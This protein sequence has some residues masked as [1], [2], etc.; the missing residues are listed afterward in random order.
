MH[1]LLTQIVAS[2]WLISPALAQ[3][4][5]PMLESMAQGQQPTGVGADAALAR[6]KQARPRDY[7]VL[8][9]AGGAV[10]AVAPIAGG[11][12]TAKSESNSLNV[13][14]IGISGPLLKDDQECGPLGMSTLAR[15]VQAL[16]ND[17]HVDAVVFKIDSPGGQVY[18]TQTLADAIMQC[19]KPTV[20]LCDDGLMCS[21]AYW[22]GASC[23]RVLATHETCTIGS[24]GVMASWA[25]KSGKLEKE[26]VVFHEVYA[27][28]ST[29]KNADFAAAKAG[30]YGP[31]QERLSAICDQFIGAVSANRGDRLDQKAA[32][33]AGAFAGDT[34]HAA[35]AQE[36]GL[37]DGIGSLQDAFALC[38][39]LVQEQ[40]VAS[41]ASSSTS[42]TMG[43]F[44]KKA[45]FGPAM[46]ALVG[47]ETVTAEMATAANAE[48][49]AGGIAGAALITPAALQPLEVAAGQVT[50]L[51]AS[52]TTAQGQLTAMTEALTTAGATDVA[53]LATDRDAWKEKAETYGSQAGTMGTSAKREGAEIQEGTPATAAQKAIDEL[54][55]NAAL[56]NH[57]MFGGK[58]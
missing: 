26:G 4:Y 7:A 38:A 19:G 43:I 5:L 10:A 28:Q 45:A 31:M 23:D 16:G 8:Y 13:R 54:P 53:A 51:T 55:H 42:S 36:M 17:P 20:A 25:D 30:D 39:E 6:R 48:L 34:F 50:T 15:Y 1:P 33:K 41:T 18:G 47:A 27:S 37:I 52:L 11:K 22:I 44:D 3:Q 21:A 58:K 14:V 12:A 49:V 32:K 24:I 9:A 56:D 29:K 46:L 2:P 35:E 40:R 57:P